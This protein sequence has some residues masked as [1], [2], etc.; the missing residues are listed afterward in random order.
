MFQKQLVRLVK[1]YVY[2]SPNLNLTFQMFLDR[3]D[4]SVVPLKLIDQN[5]GKHQQRTKLTVLECKSSDKFS[6]KNNGST[7]SLH[8]IYIPHF[9]TNILTKKKKLIFF[10][11]YIKLENSDWS[12]LRIE[13]NIFSLPQDVFSIEIQSLFSNL[14]LSC[15]KKIIFFKSYPKVIHEPQLLGRLLVG[16]SVGIGHLHSGG[17]APYRVGHHLVCCHLWQCLNYVL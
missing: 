4:D 8:C 17:R 15:K 11:D 12:Q 1:K 6:L 2:F 10:K 5:I 14:L 9:L 16:L 7:E 13:P 3:K